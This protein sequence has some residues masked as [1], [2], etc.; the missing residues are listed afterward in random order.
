MPLNV[1][2]YHEYVLDSVSDGLG[3]F[4]TLTPIVHPGKGDARGTNQRLAKE[5]SRSVTVLKRAAMSFRDCAPGK[6][7]SLLIGSETPLVVVARESDKQDGPWD[8]KVQYQPGPDAKKDRKS[9]KPWTKGFTTP[10]GRNQLSVNAN[11]PG[12]YSIIDVKGQYCP[13]DVLSPETCRVVL[14]PYPTAEITWKRIH[15]WWVFNLLNH[16]LS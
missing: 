8:V 9:P 12:E 16:S 13:G 1:P 2:G 7:A 10:T 3:N 15:E 6:P 14:Q 5:T 4:Q 11:A